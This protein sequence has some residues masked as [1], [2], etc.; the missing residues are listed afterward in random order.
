MIPGHLILSATGVIQ[1]MNEGV[2]SLLRVKADQWIGRS[3]EELWTESGFSPPPPED[4]DTPPT[5]T[6][7]NREQEG[8]MVSRADS[9]PPRTLGW[10]A[11]HLVEGGTLT[12]FVWLLWE[13]SGPTEGSAQTLVSYRDTFTHAIEGI[14]RTT[15]DGRYLE[16]NPALARMYGYESPTGLIAA[17]ADLNTQLYVEPGRRAEFIFQIWVN[18]YVSNFE[19]QVYRADGSLIWIAEFARILGVGHLVPESLL[20]PAIERI[21]ESL[22]YLRADVGQAIAAKVIL[23]RDGVGVFDEAA[24]DVWTEDIGDRCSGTWVTLGRCPG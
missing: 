12:G 6:G 22:L 5:V 11:S 17:L 20:A 2:A 23:E 3:V 4:T 1:A 9:L 16:V 14:Y 18:G 24:K 7:A 10:R 13:K 21:P 8:V 15:M 19:S